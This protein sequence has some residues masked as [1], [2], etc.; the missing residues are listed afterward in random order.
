[1]ENNE[2][3]EKAHYWS[4]GSGAVHKLIETVQFLL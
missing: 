2:N 1:M 4:A 3:C